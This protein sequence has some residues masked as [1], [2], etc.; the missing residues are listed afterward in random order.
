MRL[1]IDTNV[2]LSGLLWRGAPHR[3]MEQAHSGAVS[4]VSSPA[5]LEELGDV[6]ARE[7]FAGILARSGCTAN[8]ILDDIQRLAHLVTPLPLPEPVCCDP[9]DDAVLAVALAAQADL[10]VSG[11]DDLLALQSFRG[12]PIVDPV[13][14]LSLCAKG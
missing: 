8:Q 1:V 12:I 14:A 3:L 7:K 5:L 13:E 2:M 6:L 9:D 4:L 10:I 11:D